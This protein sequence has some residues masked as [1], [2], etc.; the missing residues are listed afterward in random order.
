MM[1]FQKLAALLVLTVFALHGAMAAPQGLPP[2]RPG[3]PLIGRNT[4][5]PPG[6]PDPRGETN[7]IDILDRAAANNARELVGAGAENVE[8]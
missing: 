8:A 3:D 4:S 2:S 7:I 6:P 1:S 5:G